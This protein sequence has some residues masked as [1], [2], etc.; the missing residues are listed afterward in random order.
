MIPAGAMVRGPRIRWGVAAIGTGAE[1]ITSCQPEAAS[2]VKVALASNVTEAES[3]DARCGCP[4]RPAPCKNEDRLY[5]RLCQ[6][7]I[8]LQSQAIDRRACQAV[9]IVE[10]FQRLYSGFPV[11]VVND[12]L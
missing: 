3:T 8:L 5:S 12:Q 11:E 10:L 6:I 2:P 9:G 1:N 4:Y 7:Q